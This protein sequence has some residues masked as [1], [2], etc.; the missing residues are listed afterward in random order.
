MDVK[1]LDSGTILY[2]SSP[3]VIKEWDKTDMRYDDD[4]GKIGI[5]FGTYPLLSLAIANEYRM[6]C[7]ISVYQTTDNIRCYVGKYCYREINP[8]RYYNGEDLIPG[9]DV[10]DEENVNHFD[11]E[12][13][14]IIDNPYGNEVSIKNVTSDM[15]EVFISNPDDLQYFK[16]LRSSKVYWEDIYPLVERSNFNAKWDGYLDYIKSTPE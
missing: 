14:P 7:H 2:R 12:M 13:L 15:G 8:K 10:I 11:S 4:T 5:Y 9:V 3:V 16:F 1:V 6:N